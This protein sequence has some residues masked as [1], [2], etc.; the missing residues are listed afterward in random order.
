M[1]NSSKM[2]EERWDIYN[3]DKE[4]TGETI[5]RNSDQ[6]LKENQYHLVCS[7]M[8]VNSDNKILITQRSSIKKSFAMKWEIIGG[9]CL[10][11]ESSIDGIIREVNEEV[12]ISINKKDLKLLK[13]VKNHEK[14]Y[15]KDIYICYKKIMDKK[16]KFVDNEA[17]N[18]KW[19]SINEFVEMKEK[20]LFIPTIDIDLNDFC[21]EIQ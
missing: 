16:I 5:L 18:F 13:T 7:I 6:R 11:F 2:K 12:G 9:S 17:Q 20:E 3:I 8:F 15:I 19:I 4:K 10:E 14:K 1:E 21:Y